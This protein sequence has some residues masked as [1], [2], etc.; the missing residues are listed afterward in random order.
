M[1]NVKRIILDV[2]TGIDD[3]LAIIYAIKSKNIVIEGI[4]TG[5]GNVSVEQA[6]VNTLKMIDLAGPAYDIPVAMGA[7]KPLV[8]EMRAPSVAIHGSDGLGGYDLPET[9]RTPIEESAPNFIIRK[10]N[11]SI[12][13]LT[14]VFTGRLTNLAIALAKDPSIASKV[15]RLV[16]MGGALKVPGNITEVAEANIHGDPEAAHRV[17]ESGIP[18]TMVG[19]DVT[20]NTKFGEAEFDLLMEKLT[21]KQQA[22]KDFFYHVFKFSFEASNRLNE[23]K[24]RLMHDPLAVGVAEDSSIVATEDYY[25]YIE[26]KGTLSMGA[27][28]ADLRLPQTKT[29]AS[30]CMKVNDQLFLNRYIDTIASNE[31]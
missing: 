24:F 4:T 30:V 2:D 28:L 6:T 3:A 20:S 26:T 11:E 7:G 1:E 18:I 8:R 16:L 5:F 14:L 13:K 22:L 10:I 31:R 25:I 17:F 21:D 19:L 9:K 12:N 15:E 23:G 27:T 29:N